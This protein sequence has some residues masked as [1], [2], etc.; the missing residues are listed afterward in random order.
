MTNKNKHIG[1]S[2]ILIILFTLCGERVIAQNTT[3]QNYIIENYQSPHS[4]AQIVDGKQETH[5]IHKTVYV[6][7]GE[8]VKLNIPHSYNSD[9]DMKGYYRWFNYKTN[10]YSERV[11]L[12]SNSIPN[13]YPIYRYKNGLVR[14]K[15]PQNN[16]L[17]EIVN[18][19]APSTANNGVFDVIACDV[20]TYIDYLSTGNRITREPTLSIRYIYTI[21]DADIIAEKIEEATKAG[22]YYEEYEI[23]MPASQETNI[24]LQCLPENYFVKNYG[25]SLQCSGF[26]WY[27]DGQSWNYSHNNGQWNN[28]NGK[29]FSPARITKSTKDEMEITVKWESGAVTKN[30]ARYKIHFIPDIAPLFEADLKQNETYKKR[31]PDYLNENYILAVSENFDDEKDLGRPTDVGS[32]LRSTPLSWEQCTYGYVYQEL[33]NWSTFVNYTPY[34]SE[35]GLYKSA[36]K[37]GLTGS[38]WQWWPANTNLSYYDRRYYDS[39]QKEYGYFFY[40][41]ASDEAGTMAKLPLNKKLCSGTTLTVT[42]WVCDISTGGER[43]NIDFIFKGIDADQKEVVLNRFNTGYF[44]RA[45]NNTNRNWQQIYYTFSFDKE[46][47]FDKFLLQIDNNCTN[48][49]GA[50]Y[51]IDDIRVY[52]TKPTVQA[53]QATL[54]C[55][56]TDK[57]ARIKAKIEYERLLRILAKEENT[58]EEVTLY[59]RFLDKDKKEVNYYNYNPTGTP[60]YERGNIKISTT[61]NNM[62]DATGKEISE[63]PV[64]GQLA[65]REGEDDLRYIVFQAP[66]NRQLKY[67]QNYYLQLGDIDGHF[68]EN[69][70][71]P[72]AMIS[73]A[74]IIHEPAE[75]TADG[76]ALVNGKGVCYGSPV[77][78]EAVLYDRINGDE[79]HQVECRFDWFF[80][81]KHADIYEALTYYRKEYPSTP[82]DFRTD[83]ESAKGEFTDTH[84]TVL[85][86][87]QTAH[88]LFLNSRTI[89]RRVAKG[90]IIRAR[91]IPGSIGQTLIEI[92]NDAIQLDT[93]SDTAMPEVEIGQGLKT[94]VV[95]M[96]MEQAKLLTEKQ[97]KTLWIPVNDFESSDGKKTYNIV[98][99]EDN[100]YKDTSTGIVYLCGS[101]DPAHKNIDFKAEL[102]PQVAKLVTINVGPDKEN[103][104][105][106]SFNGEDN[107]FPATA[108]GAGGFRMREGFT[109]S[110]MF[111]YNEENKDSGTIE[112]SVCNGMTTLNICIVPQ[113]LTWT[114]EKGDNWN[115]D[116]NWKRSMKDELY[117]ADYTDYTGEDLTQAQGFVPMHNSLAT[118]AN[119]TTAPWL[120]E[121]TIKG[122]GS[123]DIAANTNHPATSADSTDYKA[124][125]PSTEIEYELE[126]WEGSEVTSSTEAQTH[127]YAG[128]LFKGNSCEQIYFKHGAEMRNTQY[129]T[130]EKAHVEFELTNN[131]W[132][133]LSSPL[134]SIVAGDMY[135]P[136]EKGRQ[137]TETFRD[138]T[139]Q[140]GT[141]NN[142]FDPAVYQRNWST[143]N[144]ENFC[145]TTGSYNVRKVGD[146]SGAYNRVDEIYNAGRGFS[147]RPIYF[148]TN[149]GNKAIKEGHQTL[150]R[151]PKADERYEYYAYGSNDIPDSGKGWNA[152]E[153][154]RATNGKLALT[155]GQQQ[156]DATL[157]NNHGG[158]G[159]LFLAGNPFMATLDINKFID[160]HQSTNDQTKQLKREY[161]LLTEQGQC[162]FQ[163]KGD[164]TWESSIPGITGGTVA[165]LQGFFVK[166]QM[167]GAEVKVTYTPDMT[168]AKP[169]TGSLLRSA[170]T[171]STDDGT[172]RL[173]IT[174]ERNGFQSHIL[175][176]EKFSADNDYNEEEDV[177]TFIDSNL[178]DQ[179]TLYSVAGNTVV[180]INKIS[181]CK[182][183]PLGIYSEN[184]EDVTLSFEGVESF[185]KE[186]TLYDTQTGLHTAINSD[187]SSTS[188]AG[189]THGRYFIC[190]GEMEEQKETS[191]LTAYSAEANRITIAGSPGDPLKE[192]SIYNTL[193]MEVQ[194]LTGLNNTQEE[195]TVAGGLYIVRI[196]SENNNATVKVAVR[197]K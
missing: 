14:T 49:S 51:A 13:G 65:Y 47:E 172:A 91:P 190:L 16:E 42:A 153:K 182:M 119:T 57:E 73:E 9:S 95:R 106:F 97:D 92:C 143:D 55:A 180:S 84:H 139:Y 8:T 102:L 48:T 60:D 54:P 98:Q 94:Q 46:L 78:L 184:A 100:L 157:T 196:K 135:I 183:I 169:A 144:A 24:R 165:P 5:E 34:H 35:Y 104:L 22:K 41:D 175:I 158:D 129:L 96:D 130:Y 114:G 6:K 71:S 67:N 194:R 107:N 181:D 171:R 31:T 93:T 192:V 3:H 15:C 99:S 26:Y 160:A 85:E 23:Y 185:G 111:F 53:L 125:A 197:D 162:Y 195:V 38:K 61:F 188:I 166:R 29:Q 79:L 154:R 40:T 174:A 30:I 68:D 109:Y 156:V 112:Y 178:K 80:G 176:A 62:T 36:R 86:E 4:N 59:Y 64:A 89:T 177:A 17:I 50:D 121:L 12:T 2:I 27:K 116:N 72:C 105:V 159:E 103:Y 28:Y 146:W 113:Y 148:E 69:V 58:G 108:A 151:L 168:I 70:N 164:G 20:S 193:G 101:N 118:I 52:M 150:F 66:N 56:S 115:N 136:T 191:V 179:P 76:G 75:I 122:D 124:N 11:S 127:T 81:E 1:I 123:S 117:K 126:V 87:A 186:I 147:I 18:Y 152:D 149:D 77:T 82:T 10:S 7:K 142:R 187:R 39:G 37:E 137:V 173:Y 110:L 33:R 44:K 131:R 132:Y 161:I 133:M 134:Q 128:A 45:E 88:C 83:L 25:S 21:M 155:P 189:S 138:I 43:A 63:L 145:P 140:Q 90:E 167:R 32:N 74:F 19:N 141:I 170:Q 163:L 120:Y